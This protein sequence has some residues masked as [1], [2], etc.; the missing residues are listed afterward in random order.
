[1]GLRTS[2]VDRHRKTSA[3]IFAYFSAHSVPT[4]IKANYPRWSESA[5]INCHH[6]IQEQIKNKHAA[7][8]PTPKIGETHHCCSRSVL[9]TGIYSGSFHETKHGSKRKACQR[10]VSGGSVCIEQRTTN[11]ETNIGLRQLLSTPRAHA[12]PRDGRTSVLAYTTRATQTSHLTV[13]LR[14]LW[15]RLHVQ[16]A[17]TRRKRIDRSTACKT[18]FS[19]RRLYPEHKHDAAT[20]KCHLSS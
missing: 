20:A 13:Q 11:L 14:K 16:A 9:R 5:W 1:M 15:F 12:P 18:M 7:R 4:H 10:A 2:C 3:N 8:E 19:K 17:H 6:E